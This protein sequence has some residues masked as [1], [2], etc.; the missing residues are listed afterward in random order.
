MHSVGLFADKLIELA[1]KVVLKALLCQF[2]G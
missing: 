2:P 1:L